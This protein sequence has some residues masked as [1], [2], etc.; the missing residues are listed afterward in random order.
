MVVSLI[1]THEYIFSVDNFGDPKLLKNAEAI[2]TLLTRLLLLE[3]GTYQSH[4][5]MGVG[6]ISKYRYTIEDKLLDLR[7]DFKSQI[8]KYLP[9]Y[10]GVDVQVFLQ[11]KIC[12]INA[13]IDNT[14]YAFF[15]DIDKNDIQSTFKQLEDL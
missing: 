13:T 8:E 4:P 7:D 9:Q 12:Y 1:N 2:A 10:Q 14:I 15:Y 11:N 3:P 5:K 6:L